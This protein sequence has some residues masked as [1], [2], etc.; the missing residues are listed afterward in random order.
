MTNGGNVKSSTD[1]LKDVLDIRGIDEVFLV[2]RDGFVVESL[3]Q[4]EDVDMDA[5]GAS[6]AGAVSKVLELETGLKAGTFKEMYVEYQ[7]KMIIC[8][9]VSDMVLAVVAS[10]TSSLASIRFKLKKQIPETIDFG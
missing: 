1:L 10:E 2:G 9:P 3:V 4:D 8:V 7:N 6:I 5:I